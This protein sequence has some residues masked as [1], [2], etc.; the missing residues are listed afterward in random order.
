MGLGYTCDGHN[1]KEIKRKILSRNKNKPYALIANTM[2]GN[3]VSFMKMYQ[4]GTI[5]HPIKKE[6][7]NALKQIERYEKRF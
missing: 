5:D 1:E 6:Y 7:K 2:K 3:P 4:C